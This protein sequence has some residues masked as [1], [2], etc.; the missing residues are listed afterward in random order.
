MHPPPL[1]F[2]SIVSNPRSFT[3]GTFPTQPRPW[4]GGRAARVQKGKDSM[5]PK[6]PVRGR[7]RQRLS[8]AMYSA[9]CTD[10]IARFESLVRLIPVLQAEQGAS[11][12]W[13]LARIASTSQPTHTGCSNWEPWEQGWGSNGVHVKWEAWA[14]EISD[15]EAVQP[16]VST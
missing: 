3:S 9:V 14:T 5:F 10:C 6:S 7:E 12:A 1:N 4:S 16:S 11:L 13:R 2:S 8:L 15:S